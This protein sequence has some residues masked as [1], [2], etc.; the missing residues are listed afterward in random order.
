MALPVEEKDIAQAIGQGDGAGLARLA[1]ADPTQILV[2][3]DSSMRGLIAGPPDPA[4][5]QWLEKMDISLRRRLRMKNV[6]DKTGQTERDV[7]VAIMRGAYLFGILF[8]V[9]GAGISMGAGLPGWKDLVVRVLHFARDLGSKDQR[10]RVAKEI[11]QGLAFAPAWAEKEVEKALAGLI[12]LSPQDRGDVE[13]VLQR[14]NAKKDYESEDLLRATGAAKQCL[15]D[16]FFDDLKNILYFSHQIQITK[17]HQA[18]AGMVRPKENPMTPRIF[19]ILTYYFDDLLEK[20]TWNAGFGFKTHCSRKGEW[21]FQ[22]GS[23]QDRPI[24]IDIY[25]VHG[26]VPREMKCPQGIDLVFSS[27]EYEVAYGKDNSITRA[28]QEAYLGNALGLIMGSSLTDTYAVEQ[29]TKA[30]REKPGWFHYVM[31]KLPDDHSR[32]YYRGMGLRVLWFGDHAEIPQIL[33]QIA[34]GTC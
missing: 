19:S 31:I 25:H 23:S 8:P 24:A 16:R 2:Y 17:T 30:H 20:A 11:R 7:D 32:E 3:L 18:V 13:E 1:E 29:L 26:F 10:S 21:I 5:L 4:R 12:P 28:V 15:G 27:E 33:G 34:Q 22:Y 6:G 14:L 9:V